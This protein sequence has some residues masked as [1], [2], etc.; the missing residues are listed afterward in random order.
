MAKLLKN[1]NFQLFSLYIYIYIY[2]Y[3]YLV[4]IIIIV[5]FLCRLISF[6]FFDLMQNHITYHFSLPF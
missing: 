5:S 4:P 6:P 1:I 3:I 2:I